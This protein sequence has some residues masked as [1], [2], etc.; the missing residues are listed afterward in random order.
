MWLHIKDTSLSYS[1]ALTCINS[2]EKQHICPVPSPGRHI[3]AALPLWRAWCGLQHQ[4]MRHY[5]TATVRFHQCICKVS[6]SK[7]FVGF[8]LINL[9]VFIS[10]LQAWKSLKRKIQMFPMYID[11]YF[12]YLR[13]LITLYGV[14][15]TCCEA[16]A[17]SWHGLARC[18]LRGPTRA[19]EKTLIY[20]TMTKQWHQAGM[21]CNIEG[22]TFLPFR[23]FLRFLKTQK[24]GFWIL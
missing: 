11:V 21:K 19:H 22:K 15:T 18:S 2:P 12:I 17:S 8:F 24:D 10:S 13:P 20:N 7:I 4:V 6:A 23:Y 3:L 16:V 1:Q 5:M 14:T 9:N